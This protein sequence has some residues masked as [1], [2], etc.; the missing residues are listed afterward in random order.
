[1]A[2]LPATLGSELANMTPTMD[3]N[4][5]INNFSAA[6][7]TY[8]N[9]ASVLGI[10]VTAGSLAGATSALK[11]GL[12]GM[13]VLNAGPAK[14]QTAI[15]SFWGVVATSA[16]TIWATVPPPTGATP[17]PGLTGIAAAL[18]TTFSANISGELS[19]EDSANAVATA[20]HSTQLGGI[21]LIP[22]P[23]TGPG[24]SPIL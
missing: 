6:F 3:E 11:A 8:F 12:V 18:T 4:V 20:I 9:G 10:P 5:A 17:P 13:S 14:I 2:L 21:A 19:L 23:P 15:T 16:A 24:P 7:E 22:P 1:M